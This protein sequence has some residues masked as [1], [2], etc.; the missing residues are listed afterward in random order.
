MTPKEKYLL[1]QRLNCALLRV[2]MIADI[3]S[4][5]KVDSAMTL[6][7]AQAGCMLRICKLEGKGCRRLR[8]IG[9]C[10]EMQICKLSNGRNMLCSM[11]GTKLAVSRKLGE[12]V[13]VEVA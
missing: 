10:E 8:E 12:Q 1:Q 7:Q 6:S 4:E 5:L 3:A 2:E 9:L 11:C 13:M